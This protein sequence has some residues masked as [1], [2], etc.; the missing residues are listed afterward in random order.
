MAG[1]FVIHSREDIS[2]TV[3]TVAQSLLPWCAKCMFIHIRKVYKL[4]GYIHV[5][6]IEDMRITNLQT[7]NAPP[8][9][10]WLLTWGM[11]CY[12]GV[13]TQSEIVQRF[14]FVS[15]DRAWMR[16]VLQIA[17]RS[18]KICINIR[19]ANERRSLLRRGL[20][21]PTYIVASMRINRY[22]LNTCC[23]PCRILV[24]EFHVLMI[25]LRREKR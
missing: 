5:F 7:Q 15:G 21:Y 3:H 25:P 11:L 19:I 22:G 4:R 23:L 9:I 13:V 17:Q 8:T 18:D 16:V 10:G 2:S 1:Q 24:D 14:C 12:L 6:C 20:L